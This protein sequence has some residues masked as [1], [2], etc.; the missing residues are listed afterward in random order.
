[1]TDRE[2]QRA[3]LPPRQS[4]GEKK[5]RSQVAALCC[6]A[7][8]A[9]RRRRTDRTMLT[10]PSFNGDHSMTRASVH[11]CSA[12]DA[13]DSSTLPFHT[14]Q[15]KPDILLKN[16]AFSGIYCEM[17][18]DPRIRGSNNPE[19]Y[20]LRSRPRCSRLVAR[21]NTREKTKIQLPHCCTGRYARYVK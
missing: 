13:S 2:E 3:T 15:E 14:D 20:P 16:S 4:E 5:C 6:P 19:S 8:S 17:L 10:S 18:T 12:V 1:M 7:S 21:L 9:V 11:L